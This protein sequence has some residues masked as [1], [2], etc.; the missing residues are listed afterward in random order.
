MNGDGAARKVE[1]E[2]NAVLTCARKVDAAAGIVTIMR[3]D[4]GTIV[5]IAPSA[6]AGTAIAIGMLAAV[7]VAFP[8]ATAALVEDAVSGCTVLQIII[9]GAQ[10]EFYEALVQVKSTRM[11]RLLNAVSNALLVTSLSSF[12]CLLYA[13]VISPT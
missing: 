11:P 5:K 7:R 8:Y 3:V 10:E 1:G 2:A 13:S 4:S 9:H 12:A 6:D